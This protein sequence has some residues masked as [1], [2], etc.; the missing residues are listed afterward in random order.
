MAD[1]PPPAVTVIVPTFNR[2]AYIAETLD[3]VLPQLRPGDDVLVVDD[4]STDGTPAL[5]GSGVGSGRW[6]LRYLRQ[7]NAGKSVALNR[8]LA[9]VADDR[10]VWIVDDDDVAM[11]GALERMRRPLEEDAEPGFTFGHYDYLVREGGDWVT[12]PTPVFDHP[13]EPLHLSLLRRCFIHQPGML[14][15]RRC[16]AA[17]GPFDTA[18]RRSQDYDMILRLSRAFRGLEVPGPLFH[19]RQHEGQRG[20]GEAAVA[21]EDRARAWMRYDAL[22]F[23]R[24]HADYPFD[25]FRAMV[26]PRGHAEGAD[27]DV[28]ARIARAGVMARKAQWG[29]AANDVASA[30]ALLPDRPSRRLTPAELWDLSEVFG[31]AGHGLISLD[32]ARPFFHAL[33]RLPRRERVRALRAVSAR[34][35]QRLRTALRRKRRDEA[36]LVLRAAALAGRSLLARRPRAPY[37]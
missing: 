4:G 3:S 25:E 11:A 35:P 13:D 18:L 19:Q 5:I 22:I 15:R 9:E 27:L 29:H 2:E 16:Y 32:D 1:A 33:A 23:E 24:V 7:E 28:A 10:L 8:A 6:P 21:A 34:L 20:A 14:V 31:W 26:R 37:E 17:V 12:R 30:A 36:M